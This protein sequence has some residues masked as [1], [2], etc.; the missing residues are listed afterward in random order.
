MEITGNP[1][2]SLISNKIM[3]GTA[4]I[5]LN[6]YITTCVNQGEHPT[7]ILKGFRLDVSALQAIL[8]DGNCEYVRF[9]LGLTSLDDATGNYTLMAVGVDDKNQNILGKGEIYDNAVTC[10]ANCSI[11]DF[12]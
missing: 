5:Y 1:Q 9:Y 11:I 6:N 10:P 3:A 7:K 4:E 8:A 2:A 12:I